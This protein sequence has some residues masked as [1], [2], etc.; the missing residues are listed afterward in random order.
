MNGRLTDVHVI[1][2][3]VSVDTT[4]AFVIEFILFVGLIDGLVGDA[5][6]NILVKNNNNDNDGSFL[7]PSLRKQHTTNQH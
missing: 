1:L 6:T 3:H 5:R 2:F 4:D 7:P